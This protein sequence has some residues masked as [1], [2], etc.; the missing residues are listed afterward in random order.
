MRLF[1]GLDEN[2]KLH[3]FDRMLHPDPLAKE[4]G[5]VGLVSLPGGDLWE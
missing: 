3:I 4:L 2:T 5:L 1:V